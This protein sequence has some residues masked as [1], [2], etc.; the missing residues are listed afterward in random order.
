[1][2][3]SWSF[4]PKMRSTAVAVHLTSPLARSRPSYTCVD[5]PLRD[6]LAACQS[7]FMSS[8]FTKKSLVSVSGRSVNT[9]C[10]DCLWL[11]F[12]ARMPPTRTVIS[13]AVSVNRLA[14]STSRVSGDND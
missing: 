1:M 14:R 9:P 7:T 6:E 8:K 11:A 4:D 12:R 10:C 5:D 13:G 3:R 2:A